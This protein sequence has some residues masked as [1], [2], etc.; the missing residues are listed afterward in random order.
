MAS[1]GTSI[2]HLLFAHDNILFGR[3]T[4]EEWNRL[5]EIL[6]KYEKASGQFH[7]KENTSI[8]FSSKTL[9]EEKKRIVEAGDA[10]ACGKYEKYLGLPTIVGISKFN[11]FRS[12]KEKIWQ[13]ITNWKNNF[14]SQV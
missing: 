8:C 4:L 10:I 9:L 3:A 13:K 1:G 14:L 6:K 12:L 2:N 11:T 5:Q 7:N